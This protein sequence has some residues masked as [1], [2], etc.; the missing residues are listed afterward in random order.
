MIFVAR[1]NMTT[2]WQFLLVNNQQLAD[3]KIKQPIS[4]SYQ[5][6]TES[7]SWQ[8]FFRSKLHHNKAKQ[9]TP[10]Q[11]SHWNRLN[12]Y[13]SLNGHYRQ[14]LSE[15][16]RNLPSL[17]RQVLSES[18]NLGRISIHP[19]CCDK[20]S[21][22]YCEAKYKPTFSKDFRSNMLYNKQ[23]TDKHICLHL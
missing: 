10:F 21:S 20:Y 3:V 8:I 7:G 23:Y 4:N 15:L 5:L 17:R 9:C 16:E 6:C 22:S 1:I 2:T 12:D 19:C 13:C 11:S 18:R 14:K